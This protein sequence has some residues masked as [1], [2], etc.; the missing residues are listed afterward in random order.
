M[1]KA[2]VNRGNLGGRCIYKQ[3]LQICRR[4][5]RRRVVPPWHRKVLRHQDHPQAGEVHQVSQEE[6]HRNSTMPL[7]QEVR[8]VPIMRLVLKLLHGSDSQ[9]ESWYVRLL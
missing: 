3:V 5:L 6:A 7:A 1:R 2:R 4:V 8:V 9:R